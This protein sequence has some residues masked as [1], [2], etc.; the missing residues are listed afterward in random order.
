MTAEPAIA[1]LIGDVPFDPDEL[2]ERYQ[3]ERD[4]RLRPDANDQYVEVKAEFSNYVHDPYVEP[5][6]TREPLFD[7][8]DIAIVGGGFGGLLMGA[9]LREAGFERIRLIEQAGDVGGTWYWNRYPGAMCDVESYVYLPLLE[10][11]GYI[12][13]HKYSFAPEIF[14][15]SKAIARRFNLYEDACFQTGV[16]E[17]RWDDADCHWVISTDR[18]DRMRA[19]FVAMA[20]GPLNRPK[21][22]GIPGVNEFQ[23][24]TFHTS[25]WDYGYT[26]G[27]SNGNL[28]GLA[29]KRV[30]IIGTGATA[31]QCI[32]HLG[33]FAKHLYVFQRTPSSV[34]FRNNRETD[35]EWAN[36]LEPGWQQRRM[37]N[38][39]I[40]VSG[41]DQEVDLVADGW[42]DI[43]RN[44]TG[45]AAKQASRKLGRRLT[46]AEKAELMEL[47]DFQKMES[48]RAR[49][50]TV[51][52]D[53]ATAEALKPWYRQFCKRPCFHDE[54]LLTYNRPNVTLVDTDG[55]GV[56][57]L[58]ENAVVVGGKEYEVDCLIFATGFEV[59]TAFTRRSGYDII[60]RDG[61]TLS[62]KWSEGLRTMHGLQSNGFP[63]CFFLG[64]T[65]TAVT[66]SVPYALNEQAKHVTYIMEEARRRGAR[67]VEAS[68]EGE[69]AWLEEMRSKARL[70]EKFY[71]S[72]TPG[73]Y[74]NEGNLGNPLGFFA[75]MYG[76]GPIKFF[77]LLD[78]WRA[79]Q[80]L[81][82]VD[83]R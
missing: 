13:Q 53:P 46:P 20:N 55:Q 39:N 59:G 48:V 78:E 49:V 75:G 4:K 12:P 50:D 26:G 16:T 60:G 27:D 45:I 6:F 24:Y 67:T 25:R 10:E 22:P 57:R 62:Q 14:E 19:K 44:L 71:S 9:R 8:V 1:E 7:E 37:D 30:G 72:C 56:E 76:A 38:F 66:V 23:G 83:L 18:G 63:N 36:S 15:Y 64:F 47:S 5:G 29:D 43:F 21:L 81:A 79:D 33:E 42:T 58:T 32:P 51:V 17:L 40:L 28:T 41:G 70:A 80:Q 54:Y 3:H 61:M 34:D 65:Q 73:Y 2:R 77:R 69:Q 31:I 74:N 82:G 11:M 35:P 68:L 52:E